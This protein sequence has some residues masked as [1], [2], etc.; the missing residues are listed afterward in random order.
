MILIILI[1]SFKHLLDIDL[2]INLNVDPL[3]LTDSLCTKMC[4]HPCYHLKSAPSHSLTDHHII[5]THI[6]FKIMS[7]GICEWH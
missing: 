4:T 2:I 5:V 6:S 1:L 7:Y 3:V